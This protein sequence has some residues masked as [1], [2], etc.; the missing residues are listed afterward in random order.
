MKKSL[1]TAIVTACFTLSVMAQNVPSVNSKI[2]H[3]TV[4][5]SG[6]HINRTASVNLMSGRQVLN[7]TGLASELVSNSISV[8]VPNGVEVLSVTSKVNFLKPGQRPERVRIMEDS[9]QTL[10]FDSK[11]NAN[12]LAV[13]SEEKQMILANQQVGWDA[14]NRAFLIEDLEDLSDFYRDRLADIMLKV[15]QIEQKQTNINKRIAR[16]RRQLNEENTRLNKATG[17]VMVE[18]FSKAKTTA[19]IEFSYMTR[20]AG[21]RPNYNVNVSEVDQPLKLAYNAKLFQNTG[22]DWDNISLTLTNAN[23]NMNGNKPVL[24]PWRLHFVE[25]YGRPMGYSNKMAEEA[26][27]AKPM[28]I[29]GARAEADFES[30]A[31]IDYPMNDAVTQFQLNDRYSILSNGKEQGVSLDELTIPAKYEY[32]AAPKVDPAAFLIARVSEFEQYDL[33]PGTANLFFANTY[34]GEVYLDPGITSDTLELSLGRDQS[35]VVKREKILEFCQNKRIGN[36][37]K[38]EIAIQITVK[39]TKGTKIQ[40]VI[41]DQVPVSTNKDIVVDGI[42]AKGAKRTEETGKLRWTKNIMGG[43]T[44]EMTLGYTIKYPSDK[45]INF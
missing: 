9:L 18:V 4:Y 3:V 40:M 7:F 10:E 17:E 29:R 30:G 28:T 45:K 16:L 43:E 33:L 34:V 39:N 14:D 19:K 8:S 42:E 21:W 13:Y 11:F 41:E 26:I 20:S 15:M 27:E 38:E 44:E 36:T 1:G 6:A 31:T 35:I 32:Y 2:D 37:T 5:P 22:V 23:P 25:N 12:M 24:H